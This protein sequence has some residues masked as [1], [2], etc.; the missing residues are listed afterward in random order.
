MSRTNTR[1]PLSLQSFAKPAASAAKKDLV[2]KLAPIVAGRGPLAKDVAVKPYVNFTE[3]ANAVKVLVAPP[4]VP[5]FVPV[6]YRDEAV[7]R[8]YSDGTDGF[9]Q[10]EMIK[11]GLSPYHLKTY[12]TC[13]TSLTAGKHYYPRLPSP[14]FQ[15]AT[16]ETNRKTGFYGMTLKRFAGAWSYLLSSSGRQKCW[17]LAKSDRLKY[18]IN[19]HNQWV[20]KYRGIVDLAMET[21]HIARLERR[22]ITNELLLYVEDAKKVSDQVD[23]QDRLFQ[24]RVNL[25][26]QD[27]YAKWTLGE[28]EL[29]GTEL[30]WSYCDTN[31]RH[32]ITAYGT[33]S[34]NRQSGVGADTADADAVSANE[35]AEAAEAEAESYSEE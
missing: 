30:H 21:L 27:K 26:G 23:A 7:A 18:V 14:V 15:V 22:T 33:P 28:M 10:G 6:I 25:I 19:L 16:S 29:E 1:T 5:Y 12:N 3:G 32:I 13:P 31:R 17:Q 35:E 9:E 11:Y 2:H 24:Y 34:S 8:Q 4:K 20:N